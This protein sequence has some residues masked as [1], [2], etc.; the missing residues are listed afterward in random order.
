MPQASDQMTQA[1]AAADNTAGTSTGTGAPSK[2]GTSASA[3]PAHYDWQTDLKGFNAFSTVLI[4]AFYMAFIVVFLHALVTKP[5]LKNKWAVCSITFYMFLRCLAKVAE[6]VA[7][8]SP[9]HHIYIV[10]NFASALVAVLAAALVLPNLQ[11]FFAENAA[12]KQE[13]IKRAEALTTLSPVPAWFTHCLVAV[14][15]SLLGLLTASHYIASRMANSTAELNSTYQEEIELQGTENAL[16]TSFFAA[17]NFVVTGNQEKIAEY[18]DNKKRAIQALAKELRESGTNS[19]DSA[20]LAELQAY[21]QK[22]YAFLDES[23]RLRQAGHLEAAEKMLLS[24]MAVTS[25]SDIQNIYHKLELNRNQQVLRQAKQSQS[26][27]HFSVYASLAICIIFFV[28]FCIMIYAVQRYNNQRRE[29]ETALAQTA[30]MFYSIFNNTFQFIGLLKPDG[31]VIEVNETALESAGLQAKDVIGEPFWETGWWQNNEMA[32]KL[33]KSILQVG[34]GGFVR[35]E[36]DITA[37]N[38]DIRQVDVSLKPIFSQ[39]GKVTLI[40]AEGRDLTVLKEQQKIIQEAQRKEERFHDLEIL[41]E[42]LPELI[43]VA[44]AEGKVEYL[45]QKWFEWTGIPAEASVSD[46]WLKAIH[47]DDRERI[48]NFRQNA[49]ETKSKC[50]TELRLLG[51]TGEPL[52]ILA[53]GTPILDETGRIVRWVGSASNI[54]QQKTLTTELEA[55]VRERTAEI[56]KLLSELRRSNDEL[57]QFAYAASHDL[58]EPLRAVAGYTSLLNR[59]YANSLD[60]SAKKYIKGACDGAQRMQTLINDLLNFARV[61]TR[62]KQFTDTDTNEVVA[63][64]LRDLKT[65]IEESHAKVDCLPLPQ[66]LADP[67]QLAQVF[68]NLISNAVKFKSDRDPAI[69]ISSKT[70]EGSNMVQFCVRDNGI[71]ISPKDSK[72]IFEMFQRLHSSTEYPGTGIGLAICKRIVDRHGGELWVQ[73]EPGQGSAFYFT[74]PCA[75]IAA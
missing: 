16:M 70:L 13:A 66:V 53:R 40:I 27:G 65:S 33:R 43:W 69:E 58:Q 22:R 29:A 15:I 68:Q 25:L 11:K 48:T 47:P 37:K 14:F 32:E 57:Q 20:E 5:A 52:W 55:K 62:A 51:P 9:T 7:A 34:Q 42:K 64:V 56:S 4:L 50:E 75:P 71:G 26:L 12:P 35:F 31:T 28:L 63:L 61:E 60:E 46:G 23:I 18:A 8:W 24:P 38:G 17:R 72:R 73:S 54:D 21:C 6:V 1:K 19:G 44:S 39:D 74:I 45:N 10:L 67:T 41:S 49:L 3:Q 36:S 30:Q 59:R 2:A